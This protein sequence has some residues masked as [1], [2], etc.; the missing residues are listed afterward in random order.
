M[1]NIISQG[2]WV[3]SQGYT[4][5]PVK[6]QQKYY[7][8]YV[9][10]TLTEITS[11]ALTDSISYRYREFL[12]KILIYI[13]QIDV[14]NQRFLKN[15]NFNNKSD[16]SLILPYYVK[17]IKDISLYFKSKRSEITNVKH[18]IN[19]D[20][21]EEGFKRFIKRFILALVSDG[22]FV[23]KFPVGAVPPFD[24]ISKNTVIDVQP[25]YDLTSNYHN[26]LEDAVEAIIFLDDSFK[27]SI[28][29]VLKQYPIYATDKTTGKYIHSSKNQRLKFNIKRSDYTQL[30][31][32]HFVHGEKA[33]D[34]IQ[35]VYEK[36][37]AEACAGTDYMYL[38]SNGTSYKFDKLFSAKQSHRNIPNQNYPTLAFS[39]KTQTLSS[40]R[41][42]GGFF[43]PT[44]FGVSV[45]HSENL[46]YTINASGLSA[47]QIV[48]M[49]DPSQYG[50]INY[51]SNITWQED[52]GWLKA[53]RSN[54]FI[55]G[56]I[57]EHQGLQKLY[58]YQSREE[59]LK[60]GIQG[61]SR[62]ED[63]VDFWVGDN[64]TVW[65]SEDIYPTNALTGHD[66][67]G[68]QDSLLISDKTVQSW[69]IDSFG[70]EFALYK[71][72]QP[73]KQTTSQKNKTYTIE[74]DKQVKAAGDASLFEYKGDLDVDVDLFKSIPKT[75]Y[76][77][78]YS[79]GNTIYESST[80]S[81]TKE[82]SLLT[83]DNV[84]GDIYFRNNISSV[85]DSLSSM[86]ST[87]F[88]KPSYSNQ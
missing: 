63:P 34:N 72:T 41:Q 59:T 40:L 71:D 83:K 4:D 84:Y 55:V 2:K 64:K 78:Q 68:K 39:N 21:S 50:D 20:G 31:A 58:P 61:I 57:Y 88:I 52:Y 28:T 18:K 29:K 24:V 42:I 17:R 76:T 7:D 73:T 12:K 43:K 47:N 8:A 3:R 44:R 85:V 45:L 36:K 23:N 6:T 86:H 82:R 19:L 9:A 14:D 70:N 32:H 27:E 13:T 48:A 69:Q 30:P 77:H 62:A 15:V 5:L 56:D 46:S 49:P 10:S 1:V 11:S 53:D 33:L 65:G 81:I 66:I 35:F 51:T 38:S 22:S 87:L 75:L 67:Q 74:S 16:V 60:L 54:G 80:N 26:K 37:K 79:L 25:L